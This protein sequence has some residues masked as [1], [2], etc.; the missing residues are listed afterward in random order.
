MTVYKEIVIPEVP[1]YVADWYEENKDNFE[2][3]LALLISDFIIGKLENK[4][5]F[6]WLDDKPADYDYYNV[7]SN[8]PIQTLVNMHQFG[9]TVKKEKLYTVEIP[10]PNGSSKVYLGK[11]E[12]GKVELF[13]WV[14]TQPEE[15]ADDWKKE[16]NVQLTEDEIKEDFAY[17]WEAN[18]PKE[19]KDN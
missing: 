18:L 11:N 12:Y 10:N 7:N 2:F 6:T 15:F 14:I 5:L 17:L 13:T 8:K 19:V 9:Y 16:K 1:K 3:N 4:K